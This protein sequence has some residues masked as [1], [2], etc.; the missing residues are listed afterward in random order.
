MIRLVAMDLD[1]T[2]FNSKRQ[3]DLMTQAV[4]RRYAKSG[5]IFAFCT[6]RISNELQDVITIL[7]EV[8]YAIS[9]NGAYAVDLWSG[10]ELYQNTLSMEDVNRIYQHFS[11]FPMMFEL[12]ADGVVLTDQN[13][14]NYLAQFQLR[15]LEGHIRKTRKGVPDFADYLKERT[16]PVG[17]INIFFAGRE[18]LLKA[19]EWGKQLPYDM[20]YQTKSNL[21]FNQIGVKK[22]KGLA[23][24]AQRLGISKSQ[25]LAI[26]DNNNDLSM[27]EAVGTLVAMENA[28]EDLK[29]I[30][31]WVTASNDAD[32]VA[33]ALKQFLPPL[34]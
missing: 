20:A 32:G 3:V 24:L 11:G 19:R 22:G 5:V 23:H 7:P 21:E 14:L 30:A 16:D 9:C 12:F 6:G 18:I 17:K 2:L 33:V 28:C 29:K 10:K 15:E 1:G 34:E 27:R 25:V 13:C 31:N 26:G 8:Q 4:I